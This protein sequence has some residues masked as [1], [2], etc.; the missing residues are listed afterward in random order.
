MNESQWFAELSAGICRSARLLGGAALVHSVLAIAILAA[1]PPAL[2]AAA[3]TW[4]C[5]ALL[6][7]PALYLAVRAEID[8]GVFTRLT[9]RDCTDPRSLAR[10][11]TTFDS[12]LCILGIGNGAQ[13]NHSL[14]DRTKIVFG[15][16]KNLGV[17]LVLQVLLSVT[18]T[19]IQ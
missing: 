2:F 13:E 10:S 7:I 3:L 1:N 9:D 19:W 15:L 18:A 5:V 12:A 11:L 4:S 6:S 16:V 17:L 8:F 14:V